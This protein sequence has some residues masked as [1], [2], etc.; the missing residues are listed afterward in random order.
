LALGLEEDLEVADLDAGAVRDL[1]VALDLLAVEHRPRFVTG[2]VAHQERVVAEEDHAVLARDR[3]AG[4][5][6]VVPVAL[7]DR[8]AALPERDLLDPPVARIT[9][10]Q[11]RHLSVPFPA[12][13]PGSPRTRALHA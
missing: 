12:G 3:L 1:R 13:S 4:Q 5:D 2:E 11:R 8:E 7:S 6:Q 10:D 9:N